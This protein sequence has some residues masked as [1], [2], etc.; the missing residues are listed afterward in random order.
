ME[1]ILYT[2]A[3][4]AR[5]RDRAKGAAEGAAGSK[6]SNGL[7]PHRTEAEATTT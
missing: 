6:P 1:A 7:F 3:W 5:T 4:Y 2:R